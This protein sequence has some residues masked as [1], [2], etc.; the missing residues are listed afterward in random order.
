MFSGLFINRPKLAMV[1]SI[2]ITLGVL[3][4]ISQIPVASLPDVT[5]PQVKVSATYVGASA[6]VVEATVAQQ[7]EAAMIGVDDMI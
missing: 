6:E 7:I 3:I 1:V 5:P 2:I 4:C